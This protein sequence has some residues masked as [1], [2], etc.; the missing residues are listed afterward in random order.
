MMIQS[1]IRNATTK[2]MVWYY[3][4]SIF[5]VLR[6][7]RLLFYNFEQSG[8]CNGWTARPRIFLPV[9]LLAGHNRVTRFGRKYEFCY[10][11]SSSDC[12]TRLIR[13]RSS[14]D[15]CSHCNHCRPH[16]QMIYVGD[17]LPITTDLNHKIDKNCKIKS[18]IEHIPIDNLWKKLT[19]INKHCWLWLCY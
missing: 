6:K 1:G 19:N 12:N 4:G 17:H 7:N 2:M 3:I 10:H 13:R 9:A 8:K 15:C 14:Q 18:S 16:R 5:G 11:D